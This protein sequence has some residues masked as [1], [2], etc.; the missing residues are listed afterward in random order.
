M[1]EDRKDRSI[2]S[3]A[4]LVL[5]MVFAVGVLSVLLGS[6]GVYQRLEQRGQISADN[7]TAGLYL[8]NKLRQT[9]GPV[10]IGRFGQADAMLI[11][12]DLDGVRYLTR[13]YCYDGWLRELFSTAEGDFSPEA[14]EKIVPM[15]SLSLEWAEGLLQAEL[16]REDHR[17]RVLLDLQRRGEAQ[18]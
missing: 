6:V 1:R 5:L 10:E 8:T 7:R 2:A 4:S 3:L 9:S 12:E 11:Y 15:D 18:P 16:F 13:I 17:I 14:G